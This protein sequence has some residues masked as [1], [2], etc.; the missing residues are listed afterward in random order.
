M[1]ADTSKNIIGCPKKI[2]PFDKESNNS[3][4]FYRLITFKVLIFIHRLKFG[5]LNHS[6]PINTLVDTSL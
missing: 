5:Y 4:L 3:L 2:L 6:N 1:A